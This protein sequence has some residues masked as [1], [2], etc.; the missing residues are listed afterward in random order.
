MVVRVEIRKFVTGNN[1]V[2]LRGLSTD[3]QGMV[4]EMCE[5]VTGKKCSACSF[6]R[7][8]DGALVYGNIN[9]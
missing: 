2:T 8:F 3:N 5:I 4:V 1:V 9:A 7:T 6:R